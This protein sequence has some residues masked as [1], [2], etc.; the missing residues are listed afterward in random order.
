MSCFS[1]VPILQSFRPKSEYIFSERFSKGEPISLGL[2]IVTF[3]LHSA[4]ED[5]HF[6]GASYWIDNKQAI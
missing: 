6:L 1:R 3:I 4:I 2:S 5:Y